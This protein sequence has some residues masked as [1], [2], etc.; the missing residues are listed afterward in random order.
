MHSI[1]RERWIDRPHD[2]LPER[3]LP[4]NPQLP[5]LKEMFIPFSC[6]R[7]ACL[8]QNM[9][10]FQLRLLAAYFLHYFNFNL[11]GEP[12]FEFFIT[13]KPVDLLLSVTER[14][15]WGTNMV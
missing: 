7:R 10:L 3:W 11:V 8:G 13:L 14:R 1:F 15:Q 6:G 5:Q 9:A 2:F 12:R 4:S